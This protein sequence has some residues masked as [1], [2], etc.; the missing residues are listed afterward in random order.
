MSTSARRG[1]LIGALVLAVGLLIVSVAAVA[2]GAGW[3]G[4][5]DAGWRSGTT[6]HTWHSD[7]VGP[8]MMGGYD[9]SDERST[10]RE[11]CL[12]LMRGQEDR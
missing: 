10:L 6:S 9:R 2:A 11:D 4:M 5:G 8:G 3:V 1:W 7:R 12:D